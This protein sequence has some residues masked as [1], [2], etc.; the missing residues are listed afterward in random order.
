[1]LDQ[2]AVGREL[3]DIPVERAVHER[4]VDTRRNRLHRDVVGQIR[5]DAPVLLVEDV[6]DHPA[7]ARRLEQRV[8]QE[9][10]EAAAGREH[11]AGLG[12]RRLERVEM[13]EHEARDR[14]VERRVAQRH[15]LRA[16]PRVGGT[17]RAL[18]RGR[19]LRRGR[20][21]ADDLGAQLR[22]PP[23]NLTFTAPNVEHA[24]HT[25]QVLVDEWEELLLVLGIDAVGELVLPPA[26][27][28][29]PG[30]RQTHIGNS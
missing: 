20:V 22:D 30:I 14:G 7:A 27:V 12:D 29:L 21:D 6:I 25:G 13:L 10:H 2:Q 4:Q 3:V 5:A 9:Q 8:V 26:G 19:D 23:C 15:R 18:T 1:V 16:C 24:P 11:A 17:T 28:P